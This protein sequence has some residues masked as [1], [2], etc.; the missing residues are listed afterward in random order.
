[1]KKLL[2]IPVCLI[3]TI[4]FCGQLHAQNLIANV[5]SY[6]SVN[7]GDNDEIYSVGSKIFI[8][9]TASNDRKDLNGA[10]S[11]SSSI[12]KYTSGNKAMENLGNGKYQYIWDTSGLIESHDY[13]VSVTLSDPS[14]SLERGAQSAR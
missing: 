14:P 2:Y 12:I 7:L 5:D 11:I 10:F 3:L 13:I 8:V 6:N 4:F 9:A 1:M